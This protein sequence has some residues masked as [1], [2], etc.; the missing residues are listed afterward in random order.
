MSKDEKKAKPNPRPEDKAGWQ[1]YQ[2]RELEAWDGRHPG[3]ATPMITRPAA[4]AR[5]PLRDQ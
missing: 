3:P 4:G 1:R 2:D 5:A